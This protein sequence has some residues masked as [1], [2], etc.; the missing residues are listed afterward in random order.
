V[1]RELRH[2]PIFDFSPALACSQKFVKKVLWYRMF[3]PHGTAAQTMAFRYASRRV[4]RFMLRSVCELR[5]PEPLQQRI[6]S[7][8]QLITRLGNLAVTE[9]DE[10]WRLVLLERQQE[11]D[12]VWLAAWARGVSAFGLRDALLPLML[13]EPCS[14]EL[15]MAVPKWPQNRRRQILELL[16]PELQ[17]RCSL[18]T[19]DWSLCCQPLSSRGPSWS[20]TTPAG[21]RRPCCGA[22]SRTAD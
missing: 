14:A 20:W 21:F 16:P 15:R 7:Y 2:L 12:A 8:V 11:Q 18:L 6:Q 3:V 22:S 17:I 9:D 5:T 13:K 1:L 19:R 10:A 4:L